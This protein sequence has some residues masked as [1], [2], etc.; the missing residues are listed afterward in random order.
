MTRQ[1]PIPTC[2]SGTWPS[3]SW[4]ATDAILIGPS[5]C[6]FGK[7]LTGTWIYA[8]LTDVRHRIVCSVCVF[9]NQISPFLASLSRKPDT[10]W[11]TN[12][13]SGS[14][15]R[16]RPP[17]LKIPQMN[18]SAFHFSLVQ[19]SDPSCQSNIIPISRGRGGELI[20]RLP[21]GLLMHCAGIV[22]LDIRE[23]FFFFSCVFC[24]NCFLMFSG[25]W[26]EIPKYVLYKKVTCCGDD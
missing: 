19:L 14:E 10:W 5:S 2:R 22:T 8:P 11:N 16:S 24:C 6:A 3:W 26:R 4:A 23:I 9:D 20:P 7:P 25:S 17:T 12:L 13:T 18:S 1:Q 21:S 15:P